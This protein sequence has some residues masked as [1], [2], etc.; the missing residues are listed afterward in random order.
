MESE[1][2]SLCHHGDQELNWAVIE[3]YLTINPL[4]NVVKAPVRVGLI[5]HDGQHPVVPP[6]QPRESR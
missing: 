6:D 5:R 2:A 3:G 4:K 1:R